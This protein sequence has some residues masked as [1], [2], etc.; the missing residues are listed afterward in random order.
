ML[1]S[2]YPVKTKI[3]PDHQ[4]NPVPNRVLN[5]EYLVLVHVVQRKIGGN[6]TGEGI[7]AHLTNREVNIG[8]SIA[9]GVN[10]LFLTIAQVHFEQDQKSAYRGGEGHEAQLLKATA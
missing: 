10:G 5:L 8:K 7:H 4:P 1:D 9:P 6:S 2:M 3:L